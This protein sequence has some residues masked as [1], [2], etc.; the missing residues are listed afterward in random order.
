MTP[1]KGVLRRS[2]GKEAD[3]GVWR[4]GRTG[5]NL[6]DGISSTRMNDSFF[7]TSDFEMPNDDSGR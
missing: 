4:G 2:E 7:R 5:L 6:V 1:D 3:L